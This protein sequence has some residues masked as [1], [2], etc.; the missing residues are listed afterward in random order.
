MTSSISS[1]PRSSSPR[2]NCVPVLDLGR[3]VAVHAGARLADRLLRHDR[4]VAL[5]EG[6]HGVGVALLD[7]HPLAV[8]MLGEHA[9][10][11]DLVLEDVPEVG[12]VVLLRQLVRH[13]MRHVR[14]PLVA[15][16]DREVVVDVVLEARRCASPPATACRR[17]S[18]A[19]TCRAVRMPPSR[20][21][22]R[23][24]RRCDGRG[25]RD[26][27]GGARGRGLSKACVLRGG[28]R[29]TPDSLDAVTSASLGARRPAPA[30]R[31]RT[32]PTARISRSALQV[33]LRAVLRRAPGPPSSTSEPM[34]GATG[35]EVVAPMALETG[36]AAVLVDDAGARA[37]DRHRRSGVD[38]RST[39][40]ASPRTPCSGSAPA[41]G[42]RCRSAG[43]V[44]S[45]KRL[46]AGEGS[47]TA[48]PTA[49]R[50]TPRSRSSPAATRRASCGRS[51]TRVSVVIAGER[52]PIVGRVAMDVCVVDIGIGRRPARRRG[53]LLRR[54]GRLRDP[55]LA[56]W[57]GARP[58]MTAAE[59]V[60]AVGLRSVREYVR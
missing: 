53:R 24:R 12:V 46:D 33:N 6:A 43:S 13:R 16:Q 32:A 28:G 41:S 15:A 19:S 57:I 39:A 25:R 18:P 14:R 23:I 22:P 34:P 50:R 7:D 10:E 40:S 52:H 37:L 21:R 9:V 4:A 11:L 51:A 49:R 36:A 17:R 8:Q 48:T 20:A 3:V 60:T 35:C 26:S 30:R 55:S 56:D 1:S 47:R 2:W 29:R 54:P 42:L 58:G 27:E 59:L 31:R 44:L 5:G 38:R 45:L